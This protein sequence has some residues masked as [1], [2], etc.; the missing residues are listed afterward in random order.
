[1]VDQEY[2]SRILIQGIDD[3]G[4]YDPVYLYL[5]DIGTFKRVA[6]TSIC[7][8]FF[9]FFFFVRQQATDQRAKWSGWLAWFRKQ[10]I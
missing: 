5:V 7:G 8:F 1:M 9:T 3:S 4:T 6:L 2:R 10:Q